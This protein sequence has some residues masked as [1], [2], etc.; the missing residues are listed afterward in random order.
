MCPWEA[1][2]LW[3]IWKLL[4]IARGFI[5]PVIVMLLREALIGALL[6]ME[7]ITIAILG[8]EAILANS[9]LIGDIQGMML[10]QKAPLV[11]QF[12]ST[13]GNMWR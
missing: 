6:P 4:P 2:P 1:P 13:H 5:A 3:I 9:N 7:Q 12:L 11:M 8:S 10:I